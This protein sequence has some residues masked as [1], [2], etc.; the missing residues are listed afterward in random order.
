[1][2]IW[3]IHMFIKNQQLNHCLEHKSIKESFP[4]KKSIL[5]L[6]VPRIGDTKIQTHT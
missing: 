1:M 5:W 2:T 6:M 3:S 4:S